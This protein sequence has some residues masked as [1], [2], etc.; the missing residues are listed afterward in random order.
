MKASLPRRTP[1]T[2][3]ENRPVNA[4]LEF[5]VFMSLFSS[6]LASALLATALLAQSTSNTDSP[7]LPRVFIGV[8]LGPTSGDES[9][10]MRLFEETASHMW[11]VE[12]GLAIAE[13]VG[14]G[15]E[16]SRPSAVTGSTTVGVGRF[17]IVGR[18]EE[19]LTLGVMRARLYG[20][21]HV[22]FDVV[23]GAGVLV[24]RHLTGN[25]TPP[26]ERCDSTEGPSL[27]GKAPAFVVGADLPFRV[28]R[29]LAVAAQPRLYLLR[30]GDYSEQ[31]SAPWQYEH[32]S[33]TRF[34][35]GVSGRVVW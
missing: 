29:H 21:S 35:L 2:S 8:A 7:A 18:Q 14:V 6:V 16:Y 15:V 22:A 30:R 13:R 28:A 5:V 3:S 32:H 9:S 12:G 17:Q 25:C 10:R 34:G 11:L 33:S 24:H 27:Y 4:E 26:R 19:Q 1:S 20:S 23:G 31:G